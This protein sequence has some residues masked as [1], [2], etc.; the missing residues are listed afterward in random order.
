M[1]LFYHRTKE[2]KGKPLVDIVGLALNKKTYHELMKRIQN[3]TSLDDLNPVANSEL[4]R[5]H[6]TKILREESTKQFSHE[7]RPVIELILNGVDAKP[8]G[9]QGDYY[10]D[11]RVTGK[12]VG[13][14]DRGKGMT[15]DNI[16]T[17]LLIPFSS[18]KEAERDIGR[19][20]VGFFSSLG[21]CL[22]N[23][24][25]VRLEVSTTKGGYNYKLRF[26][27]RSDNV[28]EL[29]CQVERGIPF[30]TGTSIK[31]DFKHDKR[32]LTKYIQQYLSFF[33][34]NRAK[35]RV[36]GN[37][38]NERDTKSKD[39]IY[40]V[41]ITFEDGQEASCRLSFER[42][43]K[44]GKNLLYSQ[45]IFV[46]SKDFPYYD[47]KID[48]PSK[49]LL[50]EG[51][52]DFKQDE[53]YVAVFRAVVDYVCKHSRHITRDVGPEF[54]VKDFLINLVE[55]SDLPKRHFYDV[56]QRNVNHLFEEG[57]HIVK[58]Y[59]KMERYIDALD[60]FGDGIRPRIYVPQTE[61]V[62]RFWRN[63][64]PG[65]FDLIRS[66]TKP[67]DV[68]TAELLEASP[69]ITSVLDELSRISQSEGLHLVELRKPKHTHSPFIGDEDNLYINVQHPVLKE[70][71]FIARYMSA[72]YVRRLLHGE[73][74][75][76]EII[77][78]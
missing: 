78:H 31:L 15:L 76:E 53:N 13:V 30:R 50:V 34:P 77:I 14:H 66:N 19:F 32:Y 43:R 35:I 63:I 23:P 10:I 22:S 68:Q 47:I 16:L 26:G 17:T 60:F 51:R 62:F 49:V 4:A 67:S 39:V 74:R 75:A 70:N 64:L 37:I 1:R 59:D 58:D 3:G 41:P 40:Q 48:I 6:R 61:R 29:V 73:R 7:Y 9:H 65:Y 54:D 55:A 52:D 71:S 57:T 2:L 45:G 5:H 72:S 11:V 33:D 69:G 56:I 25:G 44:K 24:G 42:A 20:G 18:D 8:Q 21:Y 38:V 36:N 27:A 12:V 28:E 46:N